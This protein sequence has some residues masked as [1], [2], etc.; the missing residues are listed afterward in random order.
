MNFLV[1]PDAE[2]IL[3]EDDY[4]RL[5][6]FFLQWGGEQW[7]TPELKPLDGATYLPP[8]EEWGKEGFLN[9]AQR[10]ASAWKADPAAQTKRADELADEVAQTAALPETTAFTP[11]E[12]QAKLSVHE[13]LW[14]E[15]HNAV[16]GTFG[17]P[18]HYLQPELL[19]FLHRRGHTSREAAERSLASALRGSLRDAV[20][21]AFLRYTNESEWKTPYLQKLSTDQ[22][23]DNVFTNIDSAVI[24]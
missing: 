15:Q 5:F 17:E 11:S 9:A 19:S 16:H 10:I 2:A 8:S 24:A 20:D 23:R 1:R 3:R 22:A 7:L 21:G 12:I 4:R 18:P 6:N 14:L 13:K